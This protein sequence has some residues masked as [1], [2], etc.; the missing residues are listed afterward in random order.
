MDKSRFTVGGDA[1]G[2]FGNDF[3]INPDINQT[4]PISALYGA[5]KFNFANQYG[6]LEGIKQVIMPNCLYSIEPGSDRLYQ[7][8]A[9]F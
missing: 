1:D 5:L 7:T 3:I 4:K 2:G 8:D 6:Q 9:I